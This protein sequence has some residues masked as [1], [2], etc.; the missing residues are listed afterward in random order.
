MK[1]NGK[2]KITNMNPVCACDGKR[3][4]RILEW[5]GGLSVVYCFLVFV[6]FCRYSILIVEW[7]CVLM[8]KHCG[9]EFLADLQFLAGR[10]HLSIGK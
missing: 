4:G 3:S 8:P 9:V 1:G 2:V 7:D 6:I 10:G 5:K